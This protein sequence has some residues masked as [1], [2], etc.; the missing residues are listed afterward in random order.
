MPVRLIVVTVIAAIVVSAGSLH[1]AHAQSA[2]TDDQVQLIKENCVS[3][4][5]SLNQL[6]ASD[7]LLRVNRGQLYESV[8]TKL[9]SNFNSRL[10]NNSFDAKGLTSVTDS[11]QTAL[12]NFRNDYQSYERQLAAAI[13][14]DCAEKPSEF[15]AAIEDARTKRAK[16][17]ADVGKL[18]QYID[19]YRSAVSDFLINFERVTEKN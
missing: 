8:G 18:N 3:I 1:S 4:K 15:H 5:S 7:A 11:Y 19:D 13:R 2:L 17:H 12:S 10:S 16:V 6:H 14:V 9:M